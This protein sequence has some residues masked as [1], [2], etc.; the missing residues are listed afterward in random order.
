MSLVSQSPSSPSF[1]LVCK[2]F[3]I[4]IIQSH[5]F[6]LTRSF[7]LSL[8]HISSCNLKESDFVSF[9]THVTLI[10]FLSLSL[11]LTFLFLFPQFFFQQSSSQV[12]LI[13]CINQISYLF[14]HHILRYSVTVTLHPFL[15]HSKSIFKGHLSLPFFSFSLSLSSSSL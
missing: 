12:N 15:P 6:L 4:H 3:R 10:D 8:H 1:F 14:I 7:T 11:T 5:S 13:Y 2:R 9:L